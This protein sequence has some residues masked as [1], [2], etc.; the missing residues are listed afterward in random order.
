MATVNVPVWKST[1]VACVRI[2]TVSM[3]TVLGQ[4]VSVRLDTLVIKIF[5]Q[6]AKSFCIINLYCDAYIY[7]HEM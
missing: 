6:P 2:V 4:N 7:E 3:V 1:A 5:D